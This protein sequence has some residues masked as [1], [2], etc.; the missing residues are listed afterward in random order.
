M[1]I[2]LLSRKVIFFPF[3]NWTFISLRHAQTKLHLSLSIYFSTLEP[4][5]SVDGS[6][7]SVSPRYI[8][9]DI[10]EVRDRWRRRI[11]HFQSFLKISLDSYFNGKPGRETGR[12]NLS[13]V[14]INCGQSKFGCSVQHT[15]DYWNSFGSVQDLLPHSGL[16]TQSAE[17]EREGAR[18]WTEATTARLEPLWVSFPGLTGVGQ[19][20][21]RVGK[22]S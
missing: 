7:F 6:G 14:Y 8:L 17:R 18:N 11:C 9:S 4:F 22:Q 16:E 10:H 15:L 3:D 5:E 2:S 12:E 13:V 19:R 20:L 21:A 1:S